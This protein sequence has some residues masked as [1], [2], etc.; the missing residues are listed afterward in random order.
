MWWH[1]PAIP[2]LGRRALDVQ[3]YLQILITSSPGYCLNN[4]KP[5]Q[6]KK[7]HP[8]NI[9]VT[10]WVGQFD[11][12]TLA[13]VSIGFQKQITNVRPAVV[14]PIHSIFTKTYSNNF[15]CCPFT[16]E[17]PWLSHSHIPIVYRI[18]KLRFCFVPGI[19]H[20]RLLGS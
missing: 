9:L 5:N 19:L 16:P 3:G 18:G 12:L 20:S 8:A 14:S 11:C 15:L 6:N 17:T 1:S 10:T 4:P 13:I 7:T 2:A